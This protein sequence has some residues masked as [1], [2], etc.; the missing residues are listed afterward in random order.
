MA[1]KEEKI[2]TGYIPVLSS[3][4]C[5]KGKEGGEAGKGATQL[6]GVAHLLHETVKKEKK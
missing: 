4:L 3:V 6:Y 1:N 5:I 2:L